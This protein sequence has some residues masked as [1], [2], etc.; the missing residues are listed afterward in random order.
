MLED[1]EELF[2]LNVVTQQQL[3]Q[4]QQTGVSGNAGTGVVNSSSSSGAVISSSSGEATGLLTGS[5]SSALSFSN[6]WKC[7]NM[8]DCYTH[9]CYYCLCCC[10][11]ISTKGLMGFRTVRHTVPGLAPSGSSNNAN[12]NV[13]ST[14]V[15]NILR[16]TDLTANV[17]AGLNGGHFL[18]SNLNTQDEELYNP[19][20][21]HKYSSEMRD[22]NFLFFTNEHENDESDLTSRSHAGGDFRSSNT[23]GLLLSEGFSGIA[24]SEPLINTRWNANGGGT[25]PMR[26]TP[27]V[28]TS[29]LIGTGPSAVAAATSGYGSVQAK[30]RGVRRTSLSPMS[31]LPDV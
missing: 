23:F 5:S 22:S 6:L 7:C 14:N 3:L 20:T 10:P 21:L 11:A 1:M 31:L 9:T 28:A 13:T 25:S 19:E 15:T 2:D 4:T 29:A 24:E 26:F 12:M 16:N 27:T 18:S 17:D 8:R 30:G